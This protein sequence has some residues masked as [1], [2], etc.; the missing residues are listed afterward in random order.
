[1]LRLHFYA[2][3]FIAPFLLVAAVSGTL[4]A[5]TPQ[6]EEALYR[7]QLHVTPSTTRLPLAEQVQ[8][9]VEARGG[10]EPV[11][12]RPAPTA[13]DTTRVLFSDPTLGESERTAVFVD[14]GTGQ[15]R[16]E[17]T[18]YGTSGVLPLRTWVDQLHRNLHLGEPG[19]LYSELAASWLWVLALSGLSLWVARQVGA[20]RAAASTTETTG[21]GAPSPRGRGV[22]GRVLAPRGPDVGPNQGP[23]RRGRG[24][25]GRTRTLHAVVGTWTAVGLLALSAT[26]LTWS[27]Y[28]G[29]RVTELR[30]ALSW[31]TPTVDTTVPGAGSGAASGAASGAT[32][33]HEG[34]AGREGHTA[35][36]AE[37]GAPSAAAD[38]A[39]A[40][41]PAAFEQV[42]DTARQAGLSA[43]KIEVK[44]PAEAG[45]AWKVDE[46]DRGLHTQVDSAAITL[47]AT[48]TG[49]LSGQVLDVVRFSDYPFA[50]KLA[51][52]GIDLHMGSFGL[53]N[54]LALLVLGLGLSAVVVWGY[55]MW[56]QRRPDPA[57][58]SSV[59]PAVHPGAWRHLPR[60]VLALV[61]VITV[62]VG[63]ALPLLGVSLL[64]FLVVDV[65]LGRLR[66]GRP[67]RRD[68]LSPAVPTPTAG[69]T[70]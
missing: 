51:R 67:R 60:P 49:T 7:D 35:P 28:A 43:G 32:S 14:P 57:R 46:V 47:T 31:D 42:L 50:A 27:T 5:A 34:H 68:D 63:V 36:S 30:S 22:L 2:G 59:G 6:I 4:Y 40:V 17:L 44:A 45:A 25:R 39:A 56:W 62:A 69:R 33:G 61:V 21:T 66:R 37:P 26:G 18:V 16:G 38:P 58:R 52:W 23:G 24:G 10:A 13:S 12:V 11:A 3:V 1:M 64:A 53:G 15:L 8:A 29:A 9:A 54:Q 65:V 48:S 19:R 20:R 70:S 41:T 55:R